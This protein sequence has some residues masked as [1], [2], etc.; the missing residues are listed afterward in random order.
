MIGKDTLKKG[1]RCITSIPKARIFL[2][3]N[4]RNQSAADH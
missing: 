3:L 2:L 4:D 1:A